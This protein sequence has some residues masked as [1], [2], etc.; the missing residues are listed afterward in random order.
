[1]IAS[2]LTAAAAGAVMT[3][4]VAGTS[5]IWRRDDHTLWH[6]LYLTIAIAI[7]F[8]FVELTGV[9]MSLDWRGGRRF[10]RQPAA[11]PDGAIPAQARPR[12]SDKDAGLP[13]F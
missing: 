3:A 11:G 6:A 12:P 13:T 10:R 9:V 2:L 1:M 7:A 5:R 8:P 4:L